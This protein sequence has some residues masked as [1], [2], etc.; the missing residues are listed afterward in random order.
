MLL[1]TQNLFCENQKI[2]TS[3]SYSQNVINFGKNDVS[4]VPLLVQVVEDFAGLTNLK[5]SIETSSD[6][7][8]TSSSTLAESTLALAN[9]K[10]GATFPFSFLPKGNLGYMRLKFSATGTATSGAITSGTVAG[11]GLSSH[12]I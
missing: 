8:F 10:A 11:C 12:E 5:V 1:D 3:E 2:T 7:E 4:F 6:S 9:L